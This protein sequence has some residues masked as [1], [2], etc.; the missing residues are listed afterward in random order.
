M[1][2]KPLLWGID[3]NVF[4]KSIFYFMQRFECYTECSITFE[5]L[6][7]KNMD[8]SKTLSSMDHNV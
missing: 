4:D 8:L 7:K 5:T 6:D 1:L 3:D 2:N